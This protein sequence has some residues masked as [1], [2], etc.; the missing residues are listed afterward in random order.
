M[1]NGG[2]D[3]AFE[4]DRPALGG[5]FCHRPLERGRLSRDSSASDNSI[6]VVASAVVRRLIFRNPADKT[7]RVLQTNH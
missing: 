2:L 5:M 4:I 6:A 7:H 3:D 1:A